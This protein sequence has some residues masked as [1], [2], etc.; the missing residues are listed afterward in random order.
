MKP[1]IFPSPED[2]TK[3]LFT[4]KIYLYKVKLSSIFSGFDLLRRGFIGNNNVTN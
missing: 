1:E 3:K 2:K 4:K